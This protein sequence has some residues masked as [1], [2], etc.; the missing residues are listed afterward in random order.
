M[1]KSNVFASVLHEK[2]N[3]NKFLSDLHPMGFVSLRI[4]ITANRGKTSANSVGNGKPGK[5]FH[6]D[7]KFA[8]IKLFNFS[9][10]GTFVLRLFESH[11]SQNSLCLIWSALPIIHSTDK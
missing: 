11:V 9:P 8:H 3:I 1:L 6:T 5:L 7:L 2:H 10:P 4:R